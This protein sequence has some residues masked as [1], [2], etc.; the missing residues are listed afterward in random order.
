[1]NSVAGSSGS[2]V[3]EG[4]ASN[5]SGT[6]QRIYSAIWGLEAEVNNGGF[7]QSSSIRPATPRRPPCGQA[8]GVGQVTPG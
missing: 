4:G 1:M 7:Q 3:V 6:S 5:A 2:S 8:P